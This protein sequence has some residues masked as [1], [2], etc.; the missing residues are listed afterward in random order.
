MAPFLFT[1][2]PKPRVNAAAE[3]SSPILTEQ[4][5]MGTRRYSSILV[6][7]PN[8]IPLILMASFIA[9]DSSATVGKK[10]NMTDMGMIICRGTCIRSIEATNSLTVVE[11]TKK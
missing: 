3:S 9:A 1:G 5:I 10:R 8:V 6:G 4:I 2:F 7:F 11:E